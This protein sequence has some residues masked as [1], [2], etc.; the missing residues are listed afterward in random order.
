MKPA[1]VIASISIVVAL[2]TLYLTHLR[3]PDLDP[4]IGP[5]IKAYYHPNAGF[6][7]IIPVTI[8]NRS[9]TQGTVERIAITLYQKDAPQKRFFM[10]WDRFMT[11][12]QDTRRTITG[13]RAHAMPILGDSYITKLVSF[14]WNIDSR[15]ELEMRAGDYVLVFHYWEP[16]ND[17]PKS[18]VHEFSI[19]EKQ[20]DNLVSYRREA[21]DK[22]VEDRI[23]KHIS[24]TLDKKIQSNILMTEHEFNTRLAR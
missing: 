4:H 9:S 3:P 5:T 11:F 23:A 12:Q 24:I 8:I 13:D 17:R 1:T 21:A 6:V 16:D 10:E 19:T 15:P 18:T 2:V 22:P 14:V 7:T 20:E